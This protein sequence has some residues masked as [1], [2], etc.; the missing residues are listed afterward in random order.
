MV[1]AEPAPAYPFSFNSMGPD[2]TAE[3]ALADPWTLQWSSTVPTS[4]GEQNG[5]CAQSQSYLSQIGS[6]PDRSF[7]GYSYDMSTSSR[8]MGYHAEFPQTTPAETLE[9]ITGTS[10][11]HMSR[12][13][14]QPETSRKFTESIPNPTNVAQWLREQEPDTRRNYYDGRGIFECKRCAKKT[15]DIPPGECRDRTHRAHHD[16]AALVVREWLVTTQQGWKKAPVKI[17]AYQIWNW[18]HDIECP[19]SQHKQSQR[20]HHER[21]HQRVHHKPSNHKEVGNSYKKGDQKEKGKG[22]RMA[23]AEDN[24]RK[25]P[26]AILPRPGP[27][28]QIYI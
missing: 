8:T 18:F 17:S 20:G 4:G 5:F 11:L 2:W 10:T 21:V 23:K 13:S 28:D 15:W 26:R 7:G 22:M 3:H 25:K 12:A 27:S 24:Q 6:A 19:W 9:S 1:L 16:A 14:A